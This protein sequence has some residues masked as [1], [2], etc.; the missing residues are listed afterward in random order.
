[1]IKIKLKNDTM[2]WEIIIIIIIIAEHEQIRH[3][4]L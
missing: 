3:K 2:K 1:M 4:Q